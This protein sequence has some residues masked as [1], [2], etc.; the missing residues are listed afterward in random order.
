[1]LTIGG[2]QSVVSPVFSPDGRTLAA[3]DRGRVRLWHAATGQELL[4]LDAGGTGLGLA[5]SADGRGLTALV[6]PQRRVAYWS[7]EP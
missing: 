1:V 4:T 2:D 6:G 7:A 3:C 5:F